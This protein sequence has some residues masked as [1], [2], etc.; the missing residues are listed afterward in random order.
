MNRR[1]M[2]ERLII[3]RVQGAFCSDLEQGLDEAVR[4]IKEGYKGGA[5]SNSSGNY[6]FE[7]TQKLLN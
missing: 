3:I 1:K 2:M 6:Q 4:L 7:V 5:D